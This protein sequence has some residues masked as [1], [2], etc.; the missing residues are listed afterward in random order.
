MAATEYIAP[1]TT[2]FSGA[3]FTLADGETRAVFT[4]TELGPGESVILEVEYTLNNFRHV[5]DK[6]F[7]GLVLHDVVT[8]QWI[9]GP[10]TF[11]LT[12]SP[13]ANSVGV[14]TE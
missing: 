10:G 13:T 12:K 8:F 2:A 4:D 7:R 11:R 1:T 3:K 5:E 6:D 14:Y 9:N